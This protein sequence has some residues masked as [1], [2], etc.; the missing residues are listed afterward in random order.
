MSIMSRETERYFDGPDD[1]PDTWAPELQQSHVLHRR[2][3][4]SP[5]QRR[6]STEEDHGPEVQHAVTKPRAALAWQK[7]S[8]AWRGSG[9]GDVY[10]A[11]GEWRGT[12]DW[13]SGSPDGVQYNG[14][15]N[16]G[17]RFVL[18][19]NLQDTYDDRTSQLPRASSATPRS[20]IGALVVRTL[21]QPVNHCKKKTRTGTWTDSQLATAV[22]VVDEGSKIAAAA[23]DA[24]ILQSS[25]RDHLYGRTLKQKKGRQGVLN[26]EEESALVKWILEMQEHAHP[27][28]IFELTRKVAE[29]TQEHWTP[30]KD[31]IPGR[32]WLRWF[33][34][35]HPELTLRFAQGLE[36]GCA[37][38]LNPSSVS[39]FYDNLQKAY[40]RHEYSPFHIWNADESGAQAGQNGSDTLVFARCGNRSVHTTIPNSKEHLTVFSC[41]NAIGHHVPNFYIFKGK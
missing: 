18:P 23:R 30:F 37:R 4:W 24:G 40:E 38:G 32:G 19:I 15:S 21:A 1:V 28:S 39:S 10:S 25:L 12:R 11:K 35:R 17:V 9:E 6:C 27:I 8:F 33:R 22:A 13:A 3:A 20:V 7:T 2:G 34:N 16:D 31:G 26:E 29:I 5:Y 14:A 36:E 41:V